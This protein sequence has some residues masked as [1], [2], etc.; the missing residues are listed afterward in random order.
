MQYLY[1]SIL[2][3]CVGFTFTKI[4]ILTQYRRIF[5]VKE[6]RIPIYVVMGLCIAS[7][8]VALFTFMFTCTP[9]DAFWNVMKRPF[10]KCLNENVYVSHNTCSS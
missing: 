10:A 6:A 4:S 8:T 1:W 7:G 2:T 9:I 3:Y 5:S